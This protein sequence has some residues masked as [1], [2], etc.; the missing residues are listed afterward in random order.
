VKPTPRA[1][2]KPGYSWRAT[3]RAMRGIPTA[4][5]PLILTGVHPL[6]SFFILWRLKGLGYSGCRVVASANGL[7]V[8]AHR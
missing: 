7:V 6:A 8:H 3:W 4:H 1:A 2:K 5:F